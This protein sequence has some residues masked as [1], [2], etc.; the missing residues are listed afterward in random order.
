MICNIYYICKYWISFVSDMS[1]D[2]ENIKF[3]SL[4]KMKIIKLGKLGRL[5]VVGVLHISKKKTRETNGRQ[6]YSQ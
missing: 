3:N 4:K 6:S 5:K 1:V 2:L